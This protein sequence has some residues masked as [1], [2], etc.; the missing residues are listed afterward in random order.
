VG[1]VELDWLRGYLMVVVDAE[2]LMCFRAAM[3]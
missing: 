2:R 3:A 1:E